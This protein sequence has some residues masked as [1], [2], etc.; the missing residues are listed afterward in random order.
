LKV[1]KTQL[2]LHVGLSEVRRRT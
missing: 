1:T 2:Q